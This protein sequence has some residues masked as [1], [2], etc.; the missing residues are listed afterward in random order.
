MRLNEG[1]LGPYFGMGSKSCFEVETGHQIASLDGHSAGPSAFKAASQTSESL[2]FGLEA[3][4]VSLNF[5]TDGDKILTGS[6]DNTAKA[7]PKSL[8]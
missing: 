1:L 5:N 7:T 6:F 4:I 3:E 8:K 2:L